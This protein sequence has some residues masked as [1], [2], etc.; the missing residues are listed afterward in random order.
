MGRRAGLGASGGALKLG[1]PQRLW[2][3]A[4]M[5]RFAHLV[6]GS[7]VVAQADGSYLLSHPGEQ[8][9][10]RMGRLEH[11]ILSALDG[12][13]PPS[14]I[15]RNLSR[16]LGRPLPAAALESALAG[17]ESAGF[18]VCPAR[19][20]VQMLPGARARCVGCGHCCHFSVGPLS[21][22]ERQRVR[23]LAGQ[24]PATGP[25]APEPLLRSDGDDSYLAQVV[26]DAACV[27]LE[28]PSGCR[29][30]RVF[31]GDL[32]PAICRLYPLF[33]VDVGGHL[34]AGVCFECPG[35]H[36]ASDCPEDSLRRH[37]RV[38]GDVAAAT[39]LAVSAADLAADGPH[40][41]GLAA[42]A[43]DALAREGRLLE[44]L[45]QADVPLQ[46]ALESCAQLALGDGP[47]ATGP[48]LTQ[49]LHAL[50]HAVGVHAAATASPYFAKLLAPLRD[51]LDAWAGDCARSGPAGSACGGDEGEVDD[52]LLRRA[53]SNYVYVRHPLFAQ[54]QRAG[55]ALLLVLHGLVVRAVR[56]GAPATG[57]APTTSEALRR[58]LVLLR[59]LTESDWPV[60]G[61]R[62]LADAATTL[63]GE[64][65]CP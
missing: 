13:T 20:A 15:A 19:P 49:W 17:L 52:G 61:A 37:L 10:L 6:P 42:A 14:E 32:K 57:E 25:P 46:Q 45:R 36:A 41:A 1:G 33:T 4:R 40:P 62:T 39:A 50:G 26:D 59:V 31:G 7:R 56:R 22:L 11:A 53:W 48:A 54:G 3:L 51:E 2:Y 34:R 27:F 38:A 65:R 58:S 23:A 55:V 63:E 12:R 60:P 47:T 44:L 30:H 21:A 9:A 16:A 64:T 8:R 18:V 5:K 43:Q 35:V 24:L 29:L 28:T